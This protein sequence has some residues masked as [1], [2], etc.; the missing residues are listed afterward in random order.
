M[1]QDIGL[2]SHPHQLPTQPETATET[3]LLQIEKVLGEKVKNGKL[4]YVVQIKDVEESIEIEENSS[5]YV[6]STSFMYK[7]LTRS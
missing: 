7:C 4:H 6:N 1:V 2:W 3:S 5:Q